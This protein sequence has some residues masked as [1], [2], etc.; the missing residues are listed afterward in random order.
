MYPQG[1]VKVRPIEKV[2]DGERR[3]TPLLVLTFKS[4]KLPD[5]IR[6]QHEFKSVRPYRIRPSQCK[7]CFKFGHWAN[8]CT[9]QQFC[10]KCGAEGANHGSNC[11]ETTKCCLCGGNHKATDQTCPKW[12]KQIEVCKIR[13]KHQVSYGRAVEI[14]D[15]IKQ[16]KKNPNPENIITTLA[17]TLT[18]K[19]LSQP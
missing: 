10:D 2:I 9:R 8:A 15:R 7:K 16:S 13:T 12:E 3:R 11:T 5:S 18:L 19:K 17:N 14:L 6:L 1:V 4:D